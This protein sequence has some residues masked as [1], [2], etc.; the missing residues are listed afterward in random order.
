MGISAASLLP[1]FRNTQQPTLESRTTDVV[2]QATEDGYAIPATGEESLG[3]LRFQNGTALMDKVTISASIDLPQENTQYEAWLID[4][5]HESSRSIGVLERNDQGQFTLT[6]IDAQSQ[7]LLSQYNRM[8]I[9]VE[10]KPDDNPNSS[11]NVAYSAALPFAALDHIRHLMFSTTETPNEIAVAVGFVNNVTL[12]KQAAD[13]MVAAYEAGDRAGA[14]ANAETIVNLIV[15]KEELTYY[16]DWNG[17]GTVSDPGDGYGLLING[18][19]AGYLDGMIHHSSYSADAK[20]ATEEIKMHA[21]HVEICIQNLETWA[22][23]LRDLALG[24]ARSTESQDIEADIR[25]A[26]TLADQ[27]L[28][29][30]DIDGNE[31]V[32]PIA[33]EGG[34][35]TAFEHAEYMS[36]MQI[37][38][39]EHQSPE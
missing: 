27:M 1:R 9:T 24:I 11:R 7:N 37:L 2:P 35:I 3:V 6:Y 36:D 25:T 34:A 21:M 30:V 38:P 18:D 26:S 5:D 29:G 28:D 32:D 12:I 19:Q 20:T 22:P 14:Q 15:G 10:P 39:G 33:G 8:E 31:S 23:E 4:D 13:A 17:D 16:S